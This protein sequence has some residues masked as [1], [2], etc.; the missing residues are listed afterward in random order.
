MSKARYFPRRFPELGWCVWDREN[1]CKVWPDGDN[2]WA[3]RRAIAAA[4]AHEMSEVV[5]G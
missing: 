5:R 1:D 2:A 4:M 3:A